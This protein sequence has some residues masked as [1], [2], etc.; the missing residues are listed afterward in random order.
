MGGGGEAR[1]NKGIGCHLREGG[2]AGSPMVGLRIGAARSTADESNLMC[3]GRGN[4]Q[5]RA[6]I[7]WDGKRKKWRWWE[8]LALSLVLLCL[9]RE[10]G[11]AIGSGFGGLLSLLRLS[12]T[13]KGA[14]VYAWPVELQ[15]LKTGWDL[16]WAPLRSK[17]SRL[18]AC[19]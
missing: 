17:H 7:D 2:R 15:L 19:I 12:P 13:K 16:V 1:L 11:G 10:R 5:A 18:H 6:L 8:G 3:F 9:S 14:G 4:G